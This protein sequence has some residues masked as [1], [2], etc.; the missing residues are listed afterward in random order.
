MAATVSSGDRRRVVF[1]PFSLCVWSQLPWG[2]LQI[3]VLPRGL[4][5]L[6]RLVCPTIYSQLEG[7]LLDSYLSS[8]SLRQ[9][10][11]RITD[12]ISFDGN[13]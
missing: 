2:S 11:T 4:P 12:C 6:K 10:L 8:G 5:R 3:I 9:V 13:R 1:A 7:E